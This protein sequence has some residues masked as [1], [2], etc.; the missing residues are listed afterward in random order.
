MR[1]ML[2]DKG[3]GVLPSKREKSLC[4]MRRQNLK[5]N[6]SELPLDLE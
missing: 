4:F 3:D 1:A 6:R 5:S 2:G